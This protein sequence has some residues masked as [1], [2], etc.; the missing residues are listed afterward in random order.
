MLPKVI[1][2]Y[3]ESPV[4]SSGDGLIIKQLKLRLTFASGNWLVKNA[5]WGYQWMQL[6]TV[7]C[8]W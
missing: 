5:Y 6:N 4:I 7:E 8:H 1:V 2:D 3:K